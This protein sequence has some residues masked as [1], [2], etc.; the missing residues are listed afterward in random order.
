MLPVLHR[1]A[2]KARLYVRM[3]RKS[4]LLSI[5]NVWLEPDMRVSAAFARDIQQAISRFAAWQEAE[6][7]NFEQMPAA[8]QLL[9]WPLDS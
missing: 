8:L 4:R 9:H 3:L 2:I 5:K 7:V 6:R 1:G